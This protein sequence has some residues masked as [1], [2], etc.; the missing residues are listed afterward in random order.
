MNR[1]QKSLVM[2]F[3]S[4][5]LILQS[6]CIYNNNYNNN[7][8]EAFSPDNLTLKVH[9]LDVGQ[10]DSIFIELP[11]NETVLIDSGEKKYSDFIVSYIKNCG[12]TKLNYIV[13]T[14]PHADHIGGLSEI[15]SE[16]DFDKIYMTNAITT[17]ST[18][19]KLLTTI[20]NKGKKISRAKAGVSI[21]DTDSTLLEFVAPV[22]DEYDNLNNYS[23]VLKLEYYNNS[24]LFTG[25]AEKESE[26]QITADI[27][28]DVLKVGHHGSSSSTSDEFLKK[29]SPDYAV[30]SCGKNND[31]GHPHTEI[32]ERLEEKN[33]AIFRTDLQGTI[34]F[35]CDGTN[36]KVNTQSVN[37]TS[38]SV[39]EK[40]LYVLN[41]SSMK[42]HKAGCSAVDSIAPGNYLET[43]DY[44]KAISQGYEP[45]KICKP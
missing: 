19:E 11:T 33:I 44:E 34:V 35:I 23:A 9:I 28:A 45:C 39:V 30:I 27:K 7:S 40:S 41:T 14:H 5:L 13:A 12:Y 15:I 31:Y 21:I 25:D 37:N 22:E 10:G 36:I 4:F 16:L 42:I 29:V 6:G 20:Q 26:E 24:F 17:T 3:I 32:L 38:S 8:S 18:Y 1:L 43:N 2:L